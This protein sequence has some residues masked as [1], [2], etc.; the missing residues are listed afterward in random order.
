MPFVAIECKFC[1]DLLWVKP[2]YILH[3]KKYRD[4]FQK[5]FCG[6]E[7]RTCLFSI[8]GIVMA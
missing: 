4:H 5:N 1:Y 8:A 3:I 7:M 6:D 2:K